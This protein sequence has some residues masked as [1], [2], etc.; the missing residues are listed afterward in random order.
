M[1]MA[2]TVNIDI[3]L[4]T[5]MVMNF[6]IYALMVT[7][8]TI[9]FFLHHAYHGHEIKSHQFKVV[10]VLLMTIKCNVNGHNC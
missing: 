10:L 4:V 7:L 9:L 8:M 3:L 1:L 6:C 5:L 2:I